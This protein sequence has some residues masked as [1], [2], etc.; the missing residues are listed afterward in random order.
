ME[1]IDVTSWKECLSKFE[2]IKEIRRKRRIDGYVSSLLYRG[3]GNAKWGLKT[4]L[5]R[6][7]D[8]DISVEDYYDNIINIKL[9]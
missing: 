7:I 2:E 6:Y 1:V 4:T 5:E 3:Q 9:K 8:K